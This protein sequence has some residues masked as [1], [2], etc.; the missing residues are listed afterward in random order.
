MTSF[1]F[2]LWFEV[3]TVLTLLTVV[4]LVVAGV[5]VVGTAKFIANYTSISSVI[6][7]APQLVVASQRR[8][9]KNIASEKA[10]ADHL[11]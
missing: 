10:S 3:N 5:A 11:D 2:I 1:Y 7:C 6:C 9:V 8:T 4:L